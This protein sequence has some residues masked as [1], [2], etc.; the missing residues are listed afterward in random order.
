MQVIMYVGFLAIIIQ[1]VLDVG[2]V[3]EVWHR[4]WEGGRIIT[5]STPPSPL[6]LLPAASLYLLLVT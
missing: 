1:G 4:A 5:K 3:Q 6:P 2:S